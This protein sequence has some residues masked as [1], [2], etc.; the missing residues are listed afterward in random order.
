[1]T[2]DSADGRPPVWIGHVVLFVADLP[3]AK[4]FFLGLG[5][6]DAEPDASVGVLELRGGTHLLLL[7]TSSA[8][9]AGT[10]APF[11]LM[12]DDIDAT[13]VNFLERGLSPSPIQAN[14]THRFFVL[15]EPNGYDVV[16]N[17]SHTTGLPV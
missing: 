15:R 2:G 9:V 16:V 6:R 11:D 17:S 12:V 1:V 8:I 4:A 7:P 5:L 3:K 14:P 10:R 13:H